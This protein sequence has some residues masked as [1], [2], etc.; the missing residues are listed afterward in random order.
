MGCR[1][2][3][4]VEQVDELGPHQDVLVERHRPVFRDDD[5]GVSPHRLQPITKLLGIGYRGAQRHHRD[6]LR[7]MDDD[8]L[9]HRPAK[10]VGQ[11]MHFVHHDAAQVLQQVRVGVEHVAQHFGG[12]DHD[13]GVGIDVG[14]A[15]E[16]ADRILTVFGLQLLELLVAQ[17]LHRGRVKD[18][19]ALLLHRAVDGEL[20]DDR[21]ASPGRGRHEHALAA[22][23]DSARRNLVIVEVEA[24]GS[25][26]RLE[27]G[28]VTSLLRRREPL[29][30]R[31]NLVGHRSDT[32]MLPEDSTL[33]SL[34]A[35][36]RS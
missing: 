28:Q 15:G 26:K 20:G 10:P 7:K 1:K 12:H 3:R 11:E 17:R 21:F 32:G 33:A 27:D 22:L 5:L 9:P 2:P 18:L 29:C 8:L 24:L 34:R 16:K 23:D 19:V 30:R 35:S 31:Q 13:A 4:T 25:T 14:V 6:M 36:A